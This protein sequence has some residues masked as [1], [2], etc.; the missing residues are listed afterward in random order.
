MR[1]L[2]GTGWFDMLTAGK[3]IPCALP[4]SGAKRFLVRETSV[5]AFAAE[6]SGGEAGC[7]KRYLKVLAP[8]LAALAANP[9]PMAEGFGFIG[10][11]HGA[12]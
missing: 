4:Q 10:I 9:P 3:P 8:K 2:R 5:S 7:S 6:K 12:L 1:C 11:V